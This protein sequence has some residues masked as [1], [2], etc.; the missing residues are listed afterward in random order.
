MKHSETILETE[1]GRQSWS[2]VI[3]FLELCASSDA[4]MLRETGMILLE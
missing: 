1:T 4:A 2:G 3:Q